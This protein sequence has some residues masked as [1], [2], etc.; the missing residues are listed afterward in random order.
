MYEKHRP[1]FILT[2]IRMPGM[3]GLEMLRKIKE[4]DPKCNSII[5][6]VVTAEESKKEAKA[7]GVKA[8][9]VKP[10]TEEKLKEAMD[11]ALH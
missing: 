8:Y 4:K 9:I 10:V 11:T 1:I 6:T 3:S 2:D 7:L 5:V